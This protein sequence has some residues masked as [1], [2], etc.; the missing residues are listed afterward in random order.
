MTQTMTAQ[1][2][3]QLSANQT[4]PMVAT[5][6]IR[7]AGVVTQWDTRL[8]TRRQLKTLTFH[9]LTDIGITRTQARTEAARK[10]WQL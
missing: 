1:T 7:F 8:R 2:L 10:F 4:L 6:A 9:Q 3:S 5:I